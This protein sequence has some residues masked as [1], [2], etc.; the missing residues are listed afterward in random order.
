[1]L[2]PK[3]ERPGHVECEAKDLATWGDLWIALVGVNGSKHSMSFHLLCQNERFHADVNNWR[4]TGNCLKLGI[5]KTTCDL[6]A[7]LFIY[8]PLNNCSQVPAA[9]CTFQERSCFYPQINTAPSLRHGDKERQKM[10]VFRTSVFPI[11]HTSKI[12]NLFKVILPTLYHSWYSKGDRTMHLLA[13]KTNEYQ[14]NHK[15]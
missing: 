1:M 10:C 9:P 5:L 2:N 13:Y 14:I 7:L 15:L 3:N 12:R 4:L 11:T 6:H 8:T